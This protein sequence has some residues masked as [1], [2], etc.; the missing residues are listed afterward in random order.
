[1]TSK[2]LH[3]DI[4]TYCDLDLKKVGVY[5]YASHPSFTIL[6]FAYAY[7]AYSITCI[8]L[9]RESI[10]NE[11]IEDLT[12]PDVIKVAH[13]VNFEMVCLE[14][15]FMLDIDP[16][17]WACTMV[18]AL[19]QG[20]P[21]SLAQVGSVLG[22]EE[23]K[24]SIGT[25]LIN[26][27]SKPCKPTKSNGNRT[28]NLPKHEPEKW[29][30][31]KEYCIRDVEV[32]QNI[33]ERLHEF[34]QPSFERD[35]YI[36]DK[37]INDTGVLIDH[38]FVENAVNI[39]YEI[40]EDHKQ[41]L[42][43]LT[44][45]SNPKSAAQFKQYLKSKGYVFDKFTKD[46]AVQ[47]MEEVEDKEV[48]K[49]VEL[50]LLLSKTSVAKYDAML[51]AECDD[52]RIRGLF[53]YY[54]AN[55]TGRWAGRLVQLQNL[56]QNH[57]E[58]L[59]MVRELVKENDREILELLYSNVPDVLSQLIRTALIPEEGKKF[60][61]ADFSAIEARVI[62]WLAN[63]KWRMKVFETHGK[64]YEASASQMFKVPIDQITKG[65]D[66]RQKGKVSELALGYGGGPN[67]LIS[68]GALQQGIDENELPKLVKMWRNANPN[69]T[70]LWNDIGNLAFDALEST[71]PV[72]YS[73]GIV[74]A[75]K[76]GNLLLKLPSGRKLVYQKA[77][78]IAGARGNKITYA[79][80]NQT[81]RKWES[82]DT[83]GGK[84]VEN[85]VQAIARD[86]LAVSMLELDKRGYK[87]VAHVHDEVIIEANT[88]DSVE[89]VCNIMS[90]P[91]EWAPGLILKADGYE[92]MFYKK[93]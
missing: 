3:I 31:F 91:I 79:G 74:M 51:R 28:R 38:E 65:S 48:K 72:R 16:K 82:T 71:R 43:K 14:N 92:T 15:Y 29:E 47:F 27:F 86:C 68:M 50:K 89:E 10:P 5:A 59:E 46:V 60:I 54:G 93:D 6:L 20:L 52:G 35:V 7:N 85:I 78:I 32:E 66:L 30:A 75:N 81:S 17:E 67:A 77:K 36:L 70:R 41:E 8:D 61:V 1:M 22:L 12:N 53:Q 56:P 9:T 40:S 45:V 49:A 57:M 42:I 90:E 13:S 83:W 25:A 62:S 80:I 76:K 37:K 19:H 34:S 26:Y 23:Q 24:M 58:E 84:L 33:Y 44:G 73:K 39:D 87:I 63:E 88:N 21:G 55:R 18:M 4:E 11:V 69:I 64:I 2:I